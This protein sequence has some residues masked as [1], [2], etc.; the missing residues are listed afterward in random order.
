MADP[1]EQREVPRIA[2][3]GRPPARTQDGLVVWLADLSTK[4]ARLTLTDQLH[5]G[6]T[7]T[8]ELAPPLGTLTLSARVIWTT[9]YGSEQT[10][11]GEH[12]ALYQSGV[13]FLGLTPEQ[14]TA[15]QGMVQVLAQGK[16]GHGSP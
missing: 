14:R 6:T 8:I 10:P 16:R 7:L 1:L 3:V 4:G 11:D 5:P 15:L 13:V 12:H 9:T 2:L